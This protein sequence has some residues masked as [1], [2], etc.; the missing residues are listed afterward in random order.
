MVQAALDAAQRGRTCLVIA[1]RLSTIRGADRI[2]VLEEGVIV[3]DGRETF[4]ERLTLFFFIRGSGEL[5]L[6][7]RALH[8][9]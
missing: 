1:H 7:R 9:S 2:L 5:G 3:E 4:S 8:S 6:P